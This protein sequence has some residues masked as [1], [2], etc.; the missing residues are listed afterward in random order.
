MGGACADGEGL[1]LATKTLDSGLAWQKFQAIC[2]A[3]GDLRE[4]PKAAH[5][6]TITSTRRGVV[7][8]INNRVISRLASLAGAPAD[9]A[10]GVDMHVRLGDIVE[11][12]QPLLSVHAEA[13]G[14]L[15]YAL[16]FYR[17]HQALHLEEEVI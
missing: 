1:A 14:E 10:A 15:D 9:P 4:P 8:M 12:G 6:H 3:Q 2:L 7:A 5:V 13:S 11:V 17:S 16:D